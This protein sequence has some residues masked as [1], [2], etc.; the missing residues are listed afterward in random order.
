[1]ALRSTYTAT[2]NGG[3]KVLLWG[4]A[5]G[6]RALSDFLR[7]MLIV[8]RAMT[9]GEFCEAVDGKTI[10]V[11][12]RANRRDTGMRLNHEGLEWTLRPQSAADFAALV[13][14]LA[15]SGKSGH[16]YLTCG[17]TDEITVMVS[18]GEYPEDL[19]L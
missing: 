17:V 6:M 15:A 11:R 13:E 5:A 9:L 3:P 2:L 1:M 14:A 16:Q 18:H 12:M 4:D 8:P 19:R 7:K 10:T